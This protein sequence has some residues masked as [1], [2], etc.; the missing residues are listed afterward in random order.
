MSRRCSVQALFQRGVVAEWEDDDERAVPL[1]ESALAVARELN[2]AQAVGD[3]LYALS[4]AA[5]RRGDL[6]TAER[7]G[8]EAVAAV[9][10]AAMSSC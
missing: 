7:L 4:D 9:R 10:A 6:E 8:E 3:A 1:Y 5:Y 2:D